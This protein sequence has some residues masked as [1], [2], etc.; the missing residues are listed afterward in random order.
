MS[1]DNMAL[2]ASASYADFKDIK[3]TK[4]I[5]DALKNEKMFAT[6]ATKFTDT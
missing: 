3:N 6:Q 1:N 2:L 4:S 5:Q